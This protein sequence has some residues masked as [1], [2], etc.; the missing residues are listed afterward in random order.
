MDPGEAAVTASATRSR[1]GFALVGA[2]LAGLLATSASHAARPRSAPGKR[3]AASAAVLAAAG[4]DGRASEFHEVEVLTAAAV[5]A[6]ASPEAVTA[7]TR[8]LA[9]V[10][11]LGGSV[12]QQA[13]APVPQRGCGV[14][15]S[16]PARALHRALL[17]AMPADPD[18]AC[19]VKLHHP[20]SWIGP[21]DASDAAHFDQIEPFEASAASEAP[22]Q[23]RDG[24]VAWTPVPEA[25]G[26]G[27]DAIDLGE[28]IE[29]PGGTIVHLQTWIRVE[30]PGRVR[31]RLGAVGAARL[32]V[33]SARVADLP[34]V[35]Q[36]RPLAAAVE[37]DVDLAGGVHRV[38]LKLADRNGSL[39][40]S[41]QEV[42]PSDVPGARVVTLSC[43]TTPPERLK[44]RDAAAASGADATNPVS[45]DA[46]DGAAPARP[47]PPVAFAA[48]PAPAPWLDAWL[49]AAE[50][51]A[52]K[53]R[54]GRIAAVTALAS[55][56]GLAWPWVGCGRGV[57]D[58][59]EAALQASADEVPA[60]AIALAMRAAE[61]GDRAVALQT[62]LEARPQDVTLRLQTIDA[63]LA[64]DRLEAAIAA[65][66]QGP[67]GWERRSLE[68]LLRRADLWLRTGA[69]VA[70]IT[71]AARAGTIAGEAEATQALQ[72][73][74]ATAHDELGFAADIAGQLAARE[75]RRRDRQLAWLVALASAG[76]LD[77]L[78]VATASVA[79]RTGDAALGAD[80]LAA[81]ELAAGH[82]TEAA[83]ALR[84]VPAFRK[85]SATFELEAKI[86]EALGQRD[87]AIAALREASRR[88][89][90]R[91]ELRARL[92]RLLPDVGLD[93]AGEGDA[94][95]RARAVLARP[96]PTESLRTAWRRTR[97]VE[98]APG[99]MQRYEGEI[100][101][102]GKGGPSEHRV[103]VDVVPSQSSAEVLRALVLR[104][105]GRVVRGVETGV[106][107]IGEASWGLYYDLEQHWVRFRDLQAGD[108]LLLEV[109]VRDFAADPF[110][111]VFGELMFLGESRPIDEVEVEVAL[112]PGAPVRAAVTGPQAAKIR[113]EIKRRADGGSTVWV[114]GEGIAAVAMERSMPGA[115]EVLPTLHVSSFA[116]WD[117][118][119]AHWSALL[120]ASQ[121]APGSDAQL[122]GLATRL[123]ADASD[124]MARIAAL[125]RFAADQIRYVGLEFGV[126][127][128][129]PY[130]V[131][132]VLARSFGDC[133]DKATLLAA[134]L[135]EVG[136]DAEVTL[137]RT[138]SNGRV[139]PGIASLAP[140]DHAIVWLPKQ[141]LW[142]DPTVRFHGPGEL[143][144]GD[145]GGQALRVP[146]S[147]PATGA[148]LVELPW[149][150]P[151]ANGRSEDLTLTLQP[152]GSGE[153]TL[154]IT[155]HGQ[156]AAAARE[157]LAVERTRKERL[158]ADL[159]RRF[160]GLR[161]AR[162][163]VDGVVG[164]FGVQAL[165]VRVEGKAPGLARRDGDRLVLAPLQRSAS[166]RDSLG[167]T[168]ERTHPLLL[169]IPEREERKVRV[170]AP[171]GWALERLPA[172]QATKSDGLAFALEAAALPGAK[173]ATVTLRSQL[174][175]ALSRV[176]AA[177]APAWTKALDPIDAAT[178]QGL[179]FRAGAVPAAAPAV[180]PGA[181]P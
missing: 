4:V 45:A 96:V 89:P 123:T 144:E 37:V 126:H 98:L 1:R 149:P 83:E 97:I 179:V 178:A 153:L 112:R 69:E 8:L 103:E 38:H 136:V 53:Q 70:A 86:A 32:W 27:R 77:D 105:D 164:P 125:L 95:E 181:Q 3:P 41:L 15:W 73:R 18:A 130:P 101:V 46:A 160:G 140:F 154:T 11:V 168:G 36:P 13:W 133:K 2:L 71:L 124:D 28:A 9:L 62:A 158:E 113:T 93:V 157:A 135:A 59:V 122:R 151:E 50:Q 116:S 155:L 110:R 60:A 148:A 138:G 119:V 35:S 47:V 94:V 145:L 20:W 6:P 49:Q 67:A 65:F 79:Q 39:A 55:L 84:R 100:L 40:F 58:R 175:R 107:Q 147:P 150:T 163:E 10:P 30:R 172:P 166:L 26:Q 111:V 176:P 72:Q 102:V 56:D 88:A 23:G 5:R 63:L 64:T 162:F 90:G 92:E 169:G 159:G 82:A 81:A 57:A 68:A 174:D 99:R 180:T 132:D 43:A 16:P 117:A 74:L 91:R 48:Q 87:A 141:G 152:D 34:A 142:L 106:D 127:S 161:I 29:R 177:R 80:V 104:R 78:R 51:F 143:P 173:T 171:D 7:L 134:L 128:L 21:F 12:L 44:A 165:T 156:V 167:A 146:R 129:R 17:A 85:R 24:A 22:K 108:V 170:V 121:P 114:R 31:F 131:A 61:P 52:P 139:D 137:V 75:T 14:P 19:D 115:A 33:D 118:V 120:R 109:V 66:A 54:A 76:R 42:D 25:L